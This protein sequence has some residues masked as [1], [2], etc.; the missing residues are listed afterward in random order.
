MSTAGELI[1][2]TDKCEG[3]HIVPRGLIHSPQLWF[4]AELGHETQADALMNSFKH[5]K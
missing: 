2:E 5:A 3:S 1:R 4:L